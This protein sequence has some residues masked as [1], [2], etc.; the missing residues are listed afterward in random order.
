MCADV[1]IEFG[2]ASVAVVVSPVTGAGQAAYWLARASA[3][4]ATPATPYAVTG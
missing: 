3:R 2:P 1:L 4:D